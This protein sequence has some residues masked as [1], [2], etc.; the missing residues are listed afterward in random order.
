[1]SQVEPNHDTYET[2]ALSRNGRV[3][4]E[5]SRALS[6][7]N[8]VTEAVLIRS[9]FLVKLSHDMRTPLTSILG[10]TQMMLEAGVTDSQKEFAD[11]VAESAH[12][13]AVLADTIADFPTYLA[14]QNAM[15]QAH[16]IEQNG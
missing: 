11:T 12:A 6:K 15:L 14:P 5:S 7:A 13:L 16:P 10:V 8:S 1:M 9:Q 4:D 2:L 3:N